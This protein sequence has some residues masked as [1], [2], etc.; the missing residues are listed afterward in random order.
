MF[1]IKFTSPTIFPWSFPQSF[2]AVASL[3][4]YEE[5][6]EKKIRIPYIWCY[7]E[8]NLVTSY[9]NDIQMTLLWT[10]NGSAK[11]EMEMD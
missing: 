6:H 7:S 4:K 3:K 5:K 1:S 10:V 9:L 2:L 11:R 8:R